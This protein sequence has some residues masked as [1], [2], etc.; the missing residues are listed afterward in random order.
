MHIMKRILELFAGTHSV[1]KWARA[2][3][4]EVTSLDILS[5]GATFTC[6]IL[7]WDFRQFQPGHFDI[8]WASPPCTMYSI[9]RTTGPPRDIPAAN[10]IVLKTLEI[11]EYFAPTFWFLENP[12][13]G[14]LKR[15]PFMANFGYVT[16]DY[17]QFSAEGAERLGPECFFYRKRTRFY[18]NKTSILL[19]PNIKCA[20]ACPGIRA[21]TKARGCHA[22]GFGGGTARCLVSNID[23]KWKHRIPERL[24]DYL[25]G[26]G[27]GP[28][29]GADPGARGT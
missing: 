19:K 11:I 1:G 20:G 6:D 5:V 9:A 28:G 14:L 26:E 17:C 22:V 27:P 29:P 12:D 3:D 2:H 4:Y 10:R 23:T 18:T 16:L 8:V 7:E 24:I 13:T 15:Q 21:N 25:L